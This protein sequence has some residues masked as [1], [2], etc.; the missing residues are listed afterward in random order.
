MFRGD[1]KPVFKILFV[2]ASTHM[3]SVRIKKLTESKESLGS[4]PTSD[5]VDEL[6]KLHRTLY[7]YLHPI[8]ISMH[9]HISRHCAFIVCPFNVTDDH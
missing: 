7:L 5:N 1:T 8:V 6:F 3:V 2:R 4:N 9:I